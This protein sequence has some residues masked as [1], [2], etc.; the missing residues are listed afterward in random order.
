MSTEFRPLPRTTLLIFRSDH[1]EKSWF[2]APGFLVM[3]SHAQADRFE[4]LAASEIPGSPPA[5][6]LIRRARLAQQKREEIESRPFSP[7]CLT[8]YLNNACNL[9]CRYC[10]AEPNGKASQRLELDAIRVAA[11]LVAENCAAH[12][13]PLTVVFHGG[14]EP[15]L[16]QPLV[17]QALDITEQT[18]K[19]RDIGIFRYIATNGV[20]PP[21]KAAWLA[22]RFDLIGLS[23]DGPGAIQS[24]Q[25]P[26]RSGQSSTP[27]IESS[28][29]LILQA[30]V[31]L[32][33]RVTITPASLH[34]QSEI[35]A[36]ICEQLQPQEI[37]VE[38]VYQAGLAKA[39]D[40]FEPDQAEDFVREYLRA[41]ETAQSY[42]VR[43]TSSG[44]RPA[45]IHGPYCHVFRE[46]LNLIPGGEATACFHISHTEELHQKGLGIGRFDPLTQRYII[47]V[48]QITRQRDMLSRL[49]EK[50][51]A[52]FS[53]FHCSRGCPD[54][55]PADDKDSLRGEFRCRVNM[56]L[57]Q[58]A[59]EECANSLRS[60]HPDQDGIWA[61]AVTFR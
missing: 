3:T 39:E 22:Q 43:W 49:P 21:E 20:M 50:C 25:R 7:L 28:A 5:S 23:C 26:L 19:N 60:Q 17:D 4:E 37:H 10:Y 30:G 44:S 1:Q 27:W 53:Q 12:G 18:A 48:D 13:S 15:S 33:V 58:A 29:R 40:C 54:H 38:P 9:A 16:D 35:A 55:C 42:R 11:E 32:H 57:A 2:Y 59:V 56:R 36:Y 47:D 34:M 45:E 6:E 41:Q 24:R 52:C 31:P 46:V 8:L 51:A 14:G 61:G